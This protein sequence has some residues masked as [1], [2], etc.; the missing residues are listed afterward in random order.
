MTAALG[1]H[2]RTAA[3]ASVTV[4]L[5]PTGWTWRLTAG[6][7]QLLALSP[8]AHTRKDAALRAARRLH[9]PHDP[10]QLRS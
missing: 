5:G 3:G 4:E 1:H 2:Y 9:P 10:D 8:R 7:G 6:N